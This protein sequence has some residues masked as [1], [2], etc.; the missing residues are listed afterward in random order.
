MPDDPMQAALKKI[1][2]DRDELPASTQLAS[3]LLKE[4]GGAGPFIAELVK[5]YKDDKTSPMVKTR[6]LEGFVKM[7]N[8]GSDSQPPPDLSAI[9]D[10]DLELVASE[11]V[12][13]AQKE[14]KPKPE[15]AANGSAAKRKRAEPSGR[16]RAPLPERNPRR[17]AKPA[18]AEA[19]GDSEGRDPG[20]VPGVGDAP[21]RSAEPVRATG[22]PGGVP[23][24]DGA[25]TAG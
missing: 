9:A 16:G 8:R 15:P 4:F 24:I 18:V 19:D 7:I 10:G 14:D 12:K 11:I 21:D 22:E 5:V 3:L 1:F 25:G 13:Y 20:G 17:G 2:R 23:Q 6:L